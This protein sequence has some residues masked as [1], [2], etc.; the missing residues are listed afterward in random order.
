MKD[1]T[2]KGK[3]TQVVGP[4]VDVRFK[5]QHLPELLTALE[6]P[7]ENGHKLTVEVAQHIGDDT[8]NKVDYKTYLNK[9]MHTAFDASNYD[10]SEV[11]YTPGTL[12]IN[13]GYV[14]FELNVQS[15]GPEFTDGNYHTITDDI[16]FYQA[17]DDGHGGYTKGSEITT[18]VEGTDYQIDYDFGS[19]TYEEDK[20]QYKDVIT[21]ENIKVRFTNITDNS[22]FIDTDNNTYTKNGEYV[23][24][25]DIMNN[26]IYVKILAEPTPTRVWIRNSFKFIIF[27]IGCIGI[28]EIYIIKKKKHNRKGD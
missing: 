24:T 22:V 10:Y 3:I 9:A 21:V 28:S 17:V 12:T 6:I 27:L 19:G 14:F 2:V 1:L 18:L 15:Y 23:Q 8:V 20:S 7:L 16:K 4:I 13:P 11:S 26:N 25:K 5:D